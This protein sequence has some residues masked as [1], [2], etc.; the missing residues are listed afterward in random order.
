MS[1]A[2]N[3]LTNS[4]KG[5]IHDGQLPA[6]WGVTKLGSQ[7]IAR[8]KQDGLAGLLPQQRRKLSL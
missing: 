5:M 8:L 3:V 1:K 4:V 7:E 6:G 2:Q